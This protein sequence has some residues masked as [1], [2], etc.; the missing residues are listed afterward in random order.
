MTVLLDIIT[1]LNLACLAINFLVMYVIGTVIIFDNMLQYIIRCNRLAF[2]SLRRCHT[3]G[4]E[5]ADSID[6]CDML[7]S[8]HSWRDTR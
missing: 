6:D 5:K 8:V 3:L 1:N 2:T 4:L 7:T